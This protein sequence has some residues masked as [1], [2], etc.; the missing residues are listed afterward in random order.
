MDGVLCDFGAAI[1]K[2]KS[3]KKTGRKIPSNRKWDTVIDYPNF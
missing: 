1:R 2:A 3:Q